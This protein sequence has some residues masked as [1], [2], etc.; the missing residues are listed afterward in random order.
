MIPHDGDAA[1]RQT[2]GDGNN[3]LE[4]LHHN[5]DNGH[6]DLRVF[7]LTEDGIQRAVLTG[8]TI[9]GRHRRHQRRLTQEA[10]NAKRHILPDQPGMK[11]E[12]LLF[13]LHQTHMRQIPNR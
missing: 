1:R 10:A 11:M 13:Q 12:A 8:H 9:D 2:D 5:A 4:E 6:G 7:G 3:D